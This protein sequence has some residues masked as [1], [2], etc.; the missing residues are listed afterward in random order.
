MHVLR[1]LTSNY[2][3]FQP[4]TVFRMKSSRLCNWIFLKKFHLEK[5]YSHLAS[6]KNEKYFS[7][8]LRSIMFYGYE[9][10]FPSNFVRNVM[11]AWVGTFWMKTWVANKLFM[12]FMWKNKI[13]FPKAL[14]SFFSCYRTHKHKNKSKSNFSFPFHPLVKFW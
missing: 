11:I 1:K 9:L 8:S 4:Q 13:L 12:T 7:P 6:N 3:T 14:K 2:Q 5:V 10:N